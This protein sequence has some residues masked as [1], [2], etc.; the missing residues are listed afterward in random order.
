MGPTSVVLSCLL[1][2]PWLLAQPLSAGP[3]PQA[4][5]WSSELGVRSL[6]EVE[7]QLAGPMPST[8]E[9]KT[10]GD[11]TATVKTC[12]D[13]LEIANLALELPTEDD[14][15]TYWAQG[16]RCFALSAL[17]TAKPAERSHL[18]WFRFAPAAIAKLPPGLA[19]QGS[20]DEEEAVAKAAKACRSWGKYDPSL[21]VLARTADVASLRSEGWTGR[22]TLF[23]RGDFDGDGSEDLLIRRAAHVTGGSLAETRV[24][25]VSQ[26][27]PRSCPRVIKD[28]GAPASN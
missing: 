27:S 11:G 5:T 8:W 7:A 13:F 21:K 12:N 4:I 25:I 28:L 23:A 18:G 1:A 17:R 6:P 16:A 9:V 3:A 15:A 24:F 22:L 19:L 26:T 20:P 14:W 10:P 2:Q